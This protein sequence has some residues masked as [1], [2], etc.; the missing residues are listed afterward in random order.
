MNFLEYLNEAKQQL[1][2]SIQA[3][4]KFLT[5]PKKIED[6]LSSEV[7]IEH[8]TDGVKLT[9]I[10]QDNKGNL[11]D[12]IFAYKGNILYSTEFDWQ[13]NTK[14]KKE[15]IGQSQFKT[16][17]QHFEK[18]KKNSIPV[19]TELF[20]E[21]LMSKPTL[22]SN[23][24]T[25]HKMVLIGYSKSTWTEKFGKLKTTPKGMQTSNRDKFAK[26]LKIDVP[27]FLFQGVMGS[28]IQ[29]EKGIENKNLSTEFQARKNGMTWD[30]PEILLDDLRELFLAVESKYGGKEE[31]V[32]I[33]Y[34]GRILKW[35][36]EYQLDQTAR[37][38]IKAKYREDD[39]ED[40]NAYWN[41]VNL[42]A[43]KIVSG[44]VIKSRKLEDLLEELGS[45]MK[46]LKLDFNHSKKSDA[47]I[48]D[49]IQ[50]SA[51]TLIIKQMRG[52][53]NALI[54][55][56]FRVVTKEGHAKLF[57]RA[58][59]LYD[60]V[61]IC[62]VT[63]KDTA[64]TK[65]LRE[66]MIRKV[67]PKAE[68]IHHS[69]GNILGMLG[70]S[71]ININAIYAGSDRVASYKNQVKTVQGLEVKEMPRTD[72]DISASKVIE[73]IGDQEF[74]EKNTPSEIHSMYKK[75]KKAYE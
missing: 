5:T 25:K 8:K 68:I 67:A 21:F 37:A 24:S 54:L 58:S 12:Y 22:S 62:I 41:N 42:Q 31:G 56:K 13:S 53:N 11:K 46:R 51:K 23:Y 10:K 19:G 38:A 14:I 17:F 60:N 43:T 4:G 36:Q 40:E 59:T 61:V 30:N 39:R 29:F 63:S 72:S 7:T 34:D 27:Q 50:L 45:E 47:Q 18:L 33:K 49:D 66:E 57:K 73:K 28:Q 74:F 2:I 65:D 16:V 70:K 55:G 35:Q 71:P 15:A 69:S 64:D 44:I 52:N 1:D 9:V 32:V 48:K 6:F 3:A 75:I 20:I 26:E